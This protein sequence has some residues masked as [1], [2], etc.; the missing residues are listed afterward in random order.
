MLTQVYEISTP[1]EAAAISAIGVDHIGVLVGD[2]QFPRE[3]P[4][5]AAA[6]IGAAIA[7]P[8]K[9]SNDGGFKNSVFKGIFWRLTILA[10]GTPATGRCP[11]PVQVP[12]F[13]LNLF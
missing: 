4:V 1:Q 10:S 12:C 3:L 8:S 5:A 13:R 6:K 9:F 2:G 11:L 7:P